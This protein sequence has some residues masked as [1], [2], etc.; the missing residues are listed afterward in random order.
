VAS[1]AFHQKLGFVEEGR[2]RE[3]QRIA[4][5]YHTLFCFGLLAKDWQKSQKKQE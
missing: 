5:Q 3:Q 1:I 4:N 2:L